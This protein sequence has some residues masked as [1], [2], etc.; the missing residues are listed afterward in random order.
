MFIIFPGDEKIKAR[1][2]SICKSL[3]LTYEQWFQKAIKDSE[4]DVLVKFINNPE[5][6]NSWKWDENLC[7]FVRNS[8]V[9]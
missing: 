1:L 3:D 8:E 7:L 9:E 6:Q 4:Y 5:D 2:D